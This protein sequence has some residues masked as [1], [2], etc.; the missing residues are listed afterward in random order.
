[1]EGSS[2]GCEEGDGFRVRAAFF[3]E[4]RIT[5]DPFNSFLP[6]ALIVK[7]GYTI[8]RQRITNNIFLI[9]EFFSM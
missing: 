2:C 7:F 3:V 6:S 9:S 8:A 4:L 1:M 5:L